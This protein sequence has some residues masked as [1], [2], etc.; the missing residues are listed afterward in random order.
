MPPSCRRGP[1]NLAPWLYVIPLEL[2]PFRELLGALG[3]PPAFTAHQ[4]CQVG[5]RGG[6]IC[7]LEKGLGFIGFLFLFLCEA[8]DGKERL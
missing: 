2:A 4:Y 3:V 6:Q 7:V 1:L 5:N 8:L